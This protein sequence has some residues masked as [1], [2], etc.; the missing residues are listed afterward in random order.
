MFETWTIRLGS[1][2]PTYQNEANLPMPP[3]RSGLAPK[4]LLSN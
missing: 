4:L 1:Q 3:R 2:P